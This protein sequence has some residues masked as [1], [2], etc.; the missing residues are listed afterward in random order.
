MRSE[1]HAAN[2]ATGLCRCARRL[3][4]WPRVAFLAC[5]PSRRRRRRAADAAARRSSMPSASPAT[6][7]APSGAP[8]IG[9]QEGM[10]EARVAEGLTSLTRSALEGIRQMPPHGGNPNLTD[11]EIERAITY[12]VNQSGGHWSEPITG[13]ADRSTAAASRSFGSVAQMPSDGRRRRAQDRRPIRVDS[14]AQAGPRQSSSAPRSMDTAA[15]PRAA[16]RPT[17]RMPSCEAQSST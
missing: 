12:M 1:L 11:I 3:T 13:R 17:S 5:M 16:A 14:A 9:D 4:S 8:K 6:G 7:R 2:C 10:G 15:C